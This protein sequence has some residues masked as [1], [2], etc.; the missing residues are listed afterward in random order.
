MTTDSQRKVAKAAR[1]G[2]I[3]GL[4]D[5]VLS[6]YGSEGDLHLFAEV[7]DTVFEMEYLPPEKVVGLECA[8]KMKILSL[9]GPVPEIA[10]SDPRE[11]II[12]LVHETL[13]EDVWHGSWRIALGRG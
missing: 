8:A 3:R 5:Y 2:R 11:A 12:E 10:Q 9:L 4:L 1:N 6:V 7:F 13:G